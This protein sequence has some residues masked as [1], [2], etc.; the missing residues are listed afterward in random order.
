[1]E[2]EGRGGGVSCGNPPLAKAGHN[3]LLLKY[4]TFG[5]ERVRGHT[6]QEVQKEEVYLSESGMTI[7][8]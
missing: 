7:S 8:L 6:Q 3:T 4:R 2:E 1:M 5:P